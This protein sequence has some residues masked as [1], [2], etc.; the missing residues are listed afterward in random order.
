MIVLEATQITGLALALRPLRHLSVDSLQGHLGEGDLCSKTRY[1]QR[2]YST[3]SLEEAVAWV[4]VLL[5]GVWI[6]A[7]IQVAY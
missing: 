5:V 3:D 2:S 6:Q 4:V 1:H 7:K